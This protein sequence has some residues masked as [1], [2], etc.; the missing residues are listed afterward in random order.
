MQLLVSLVV[1]SIIGTPFGSWSVD[2]FPDPAVPLAAARYVRERYSGVSLG[3]EDST[4]AFTPRLADNRGRPGVHA[5]ADAAAIA[6]ALKAPTPSA[7]AIT[8]T[9]FCSKLR[10]WSRSILKQRLS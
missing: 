5:P 2:T 3:F 6:A 8:L 4:S 7:M 9:A 1:G 10:A